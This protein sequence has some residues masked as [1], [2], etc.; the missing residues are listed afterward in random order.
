MS[1]EHDR[2]YQEY[3]KG[4]YEYK[5]SVLSLFFLR[6]RGEREVEAMFLWASMR[7]TIHQARGGGDITEPWT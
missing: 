6:S 1:E 4:I 5:G 3:H 7:D 2:C